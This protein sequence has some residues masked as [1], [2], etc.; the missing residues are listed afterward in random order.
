MTSIQPLQNIAAE[1]APFIIDGSTATFMQDV[2]EV[3]MTTPVVVDFWAPWCGPCKQL[4]P[5]L[6]KHITAA[7]GKVRLVKIDIDQNQ[8]LAAQM[9]VQS[10]PT[11]FAFFQGQP[12]DAFMGMQADSYVKQFI[13]RLAKISKGT[14]AGPDLQ[15]LYD[16]ASAALADGQLDVA[17][18]IYSEIISAMPTEA[19]AHI[20]L[21][22]VELLR[23]NT[24]AVVAAVAAL[25]D[26]IK[27][28]KDFAAL[29]AAL[30]LALQAESAGPLDELQ[31]T[32]A[33]Q[34][35]NFAAR[36]DLAA[37]LFSAGQ[38]DE[39]FDQLFAILSVKTDWNDG[40]AREQVLK[41]CET[42]GLEHNASRAARRR[43]SAIIFK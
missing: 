22:R 23:S 12:V 34:P 20:G 13:E 7:N 21:L 42:L 43:L 6:E 11:V 40:T 31:A 4:T 28:H 3:S 10:V 5:S 27:K 16:A 18:S 35:D 30:D 25:P 8:Q 36:Y 17:A 38:V 41:F 32:V 9:R 39:A 2:I 33:A 26:D 24:A 29:H 37:A 1:T 14:G 15:P 19:A